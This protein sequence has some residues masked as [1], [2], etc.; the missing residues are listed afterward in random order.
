MNYYERPEI[1]NSNLTQLLK[2]Y[3]HFVE[4]EQ[5][6]TEPMRLGRLAHSLII[7]GMQDFETDEEIVASI[8]GAKPRATKEY[9]QWL[10]GKNVVTAEQAEWMLYHRG[11]IGHLYDTK[12]GAVEKEIFFTLQEVECRSKLDYIDFDNLVIRDLKTIESTDQKSIEKA[13][14]NGAYYRQKLFYT[15]AT[16]AEYRKP[17]EFVF[18]FV[19]K[20]KPYSYREVRLTSEH[21]EQR[22]L[23]EIEKGLDNFK[24]KGGLE[25][26][27]L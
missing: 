3:R 2:S 16:L 1:S 5:Q 26:L 25:P 12:R 10:E 8:G 14:W 17:F 19:S 6:E 18:D 4:Y 13:I 7:E 9:K 15:F 21:W 24:N 23:S 20:T 22:A 11:E 27:E